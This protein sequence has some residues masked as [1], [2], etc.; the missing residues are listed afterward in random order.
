MQPLFRHRQST[1]P[2]FRY[3]DFRLANLYY[4]MQTG[5]FLPPEWSVGV[6]RLVRIRRTSAV[7]VFSVRPMIGQALPGSCRLTDIKGKG[8]WQK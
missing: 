5:Y 2:V 8:W 3:L 4:S 1:G 7:D 6:V